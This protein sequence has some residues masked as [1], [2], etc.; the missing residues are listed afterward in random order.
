MRCHHCLWLR[1]MAELHFQESPA[2]Q[3]YV[4]PAAV[5][6]EVDA[7]ALK[8][9]LDTHL[10][11]SITSNSTETSILSTMTRPV[12][13]WISGDAVDIDLSPDASLPDGM[14]IPIVEARQCIAISCGV[15]D[16]RIRLIDPIGHG[17]LEDHALLGVEV[18]VI[19]LSLDP[20]AERAAEAS[21][22]QACNAEDMH[23]LR[24]LTQLHISQSNLADLPE[25]FSE[26]T[27]LQALDMVENK[28]H[29][30]NK[31]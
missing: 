12:A 25:S 30:E 28:I 1:N 2:H 20:K 19:V 13:S 29:I 21:L 18:V 16:G 6:E 8:D 7:A 4:G 24:P 3:D 11:P 26:L 27:V 22:L 10:H 17:I 23:S 31:I 14:P 9:E 5:K 15:A